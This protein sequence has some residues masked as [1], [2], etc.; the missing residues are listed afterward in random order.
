MNKKILTSI[1]AILFVL[2]INPV[3]AKITDKIT[4]YK[5]LNSPQHFIGLETGGAV[6][7]PAQEALCNANFKEYSYPADIVLAL[8]TGKVDA[9]VYDKTWL[10]FATADR[11][12]VMILP[13]TIRDCEISICLPKNKVELAEKINVF[14]RQIKTDG[15]RDDMYKRWV[16]KKEGKM[17]DIPAPQNPIGTITVGINNEYEPF[18]YYGENQTPLGFDV[19]FTKR[20]ALFLNTNI[21]LRPMGY[22]SLLPGASTGI[23]DVAIAQMDATPE[24]EEVV[25]FTEGYIDCPIA[26]LI[27]TEDYAFQTTTPDSKINT[28]PDNYSFFEDLKNSI[29]KTFIKEDRWK[30]FYHGMITTIEITLGAA[31]FGTILAFPVWLIRSSKRK[32]LKKLGELYI[33]IIQG[34]PTLIILMMF[35]YVVFAKAKFDPV[36]IAILT[37]SL[38]FSTYVGEML[39]TSIES[40]PKGQKE[41]ALSLGLTNTEAFIKIIFPQ[42]IRQILPVYRGTLVNMLKSTAIVGYIAI[43]DLTKMSD[44][45]RSRTYEA[46]F[47]L[48]VTALIYFA[49]AGLFVKVISIY[50]FKLKKH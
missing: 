34:T 12:D 20:L 22:M 14:I 50:E 7:R 4:S 8:T 16:L 39:R 27:R 17:P 25:L 45:V 46:F 1:L 18:G 40:I 5:D 29:Y 47:P 23:L 44:I 30:L 10:D 28:K 37:F 41:A 42:V 3:S 38:D 43:L 15:T 13:D 26:V 49:I 6:I 36:W 24:R 11:K 48:I 2:L 35:Y 31:F 21:D 19:E 32:W 33:T 9:M